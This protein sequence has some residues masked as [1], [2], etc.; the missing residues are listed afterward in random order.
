MAFEP[1]FKK[2]K[3]RRRQAAPM[4][5]RKGG[6]RPPINPPKGGGG[7]AGP[8]VSFKDPGGKYVDPKKLKPL[9]GPKGQEMA[10]RRRAAAKRKRKVVKKVT[11][12]PWDY[13]VPNAKR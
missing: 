5:P 10:A 13:W 9:K 8:D 7:G 2:R 3:R 11:P 6:N 12:G 4:R 1:A